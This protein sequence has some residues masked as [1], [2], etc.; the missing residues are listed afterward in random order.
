MNVF[1]VTHK[2]SGYDTRI[3][4]VHLD[5]DEARAEA[6]RLDEAS[7]WASA[8]IVERPV[9]PLPKEYTREQKRWLGIK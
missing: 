7:S 1:I 8:I 6:E 3:C 2:V 5:I 9:G 4:S